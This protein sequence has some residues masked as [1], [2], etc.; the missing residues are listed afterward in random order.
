L[1][2]SC[3]STSKL[4]PWH[5]DQTR[6][7][8]FNRR[9]AFYEDPNGP[10]G[11]E[12]E[13]FTFV[14]HDSAQPPTAEQVSQGG[15]A[16]DVDGTYASAAFAATPVAGMVHP[17]T[18]APVDLA[19]SQRQLYGANV[20]L[21][22]ARWFPSGGTEIPVADY[23]G[24]VRATYT[25]GGSTGA[26]LTYE[27][28]GRIGNVSG[29]PPRHRLVS[30]T[31]D[32]QTGL[33]FMR[34][35][36]YDPDTDSFLAA[37]PLGF[38]KRTSKTPTGTRQMIRLRDPLGLDFWQAAADYFAGFGNYFGNYFT[39]GLTSILRA[40]AIR[41]A[42]EWWYGVDLGDYDGVDQGS[43]AYK[44]GRSTG[45]AYDVATIAAGGYMRWAAPKAAKSAGKEA[46]EKQIRRIAN[47]NMGAKKKPFVRRA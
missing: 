47:S 27:S 33:N 28:F 12:R 7:D 24:S 31:Y 9:I 40:R 41:P 4:S 21:I 25:P 6:Y 11:P 2:R 5:Q 26:Q 18:D 16:L 35:R 37:D 34:A 46:L 23:V 38:Y 17:D 8:A 42:S 14:L 30:R 29:A 10:P 44:V 13:S 20:D 45:I 3:Y 32:P 15:L 36:Y 22:A 43:P 39:G 1:G 19:L